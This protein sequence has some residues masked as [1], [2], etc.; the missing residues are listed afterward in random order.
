MGGTWRFHGSPDFSITYGARVMF[1]TPPATN[2]SPSPALIA[3]AALA[4]ACSPEPQ[5]RLTVCP[6]TSTGK[7]ASSAAIRATLRLSSPAW[8]VQPRITS[9]RRAGSKETR[10]TAPRTAMAARSS[11]RTSA[12][13]PPARPT[14]VRTAETIRASRIQEHV[15]S[16][17]RGRWRSQLPRQV[18]L[19]VGSWRLR[20]DRLPAELDGQ[21]RGRP[22][23]AIAQH[24][25]LRGLAVADAAADA[26]HPG[27][28][29][30]DARFGFDEQ[31]VVPPDDARAD[32]ARRSGGRPRQPWIRDAEADVT[33]PCRRDVE[34]ERRAAHAGGASSAEADAGVLRRLPADDQTAV[35]H[36]E[37]ER[38][39]GQPVRG[40]TNQQRV[41]DQASAVRA[42]ELA[43]AAVDVGHLEVG[44]QHPAVVNPLEDE[45]TG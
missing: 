21:V 33:R 34:A 30:R 38:I 16:R 28:A 10:S 13:A 44:R 19:G 24:V 11:A 26:D 32:R 27:D 14:G 9:S 40:A 18:V 42:G 41:V 22:V 20:V 15:S 39:V 12:R 29:R 37:I 6:G 3:C 1:S 5:R 31:E 2:A 8:F 7:P 25:G 36:P 45:R 4:I 17:G 23:Q 35:R 43:G